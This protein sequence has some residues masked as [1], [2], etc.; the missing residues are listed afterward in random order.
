MASISSVSGGNKT[1]SLYNSSNTISGLASGLD[2]ESMIENLVKS[3]QNKITTLNQKATKIQWKQESYR[4]I[5]SQM[6]SFSNKYTSYTSSTNLLSSSF[7]TNAIKVTAQG[8][9]ADKVTASGKTSSEIQL[10]S[11][12]DLASA[13]RY[14][15]ASTL[16]TGDG[17]SLVASEALNLSGTTTLGTLK[18]SLSLTYGDKVISISFDEVADQIVA[19]EPQDGTAEEKAQAKAEA[20]AKAIQ[21]KLGDQS[22]SFTSGET[23]KASDRIE[24]KAENGTI[25]FS[26]KGSGGNSV[27]LSAASSTIKDALGLNLDNAK[28]NK[29]A[30]ITLTDATKL[31][32]NIST[33]KYLSGKSMNISLN[34]QTKTIKLP[35]T[36]DAGGNALDM[37]AEEYTTA[38]QTAIDKAFGSEKVKVGS[39]GGKLSFTVAEGSDLLI[40][41]DVGEVLG[42]GKTAST[43][44][45]TSK[46]LGDLMP[47]FGEGEQAFVING[48]TV[49]N[50]SKD[51]KLSDVMSAINANTE[52]GVK[53][54]YSKTSKEFTFT[55]ADTGSQGKIELGEGLAQAMFGVVPTEEGNG[56]TKGKDATFSV[57]VNG[58]TPISMTRSSNSVEIDG[59][60]LNFKDKFTAESGKV[61]FKSSADSD[62]IVTAIKSMIDDY[63]AMV[64]EI[65]SSYS[66]LPS[67]KTNGSYY[68]PLTDDDASSMSESAIRQYEEKAKQGL[69]FGDSVLSGLY[70]KLSGIFTTSG[71]D[72]AMLRKMGI[73]TAYSSGDGVINLTL[74]ESKLREMLESDPD[75]VAEAFTKSTESGASTNGIMQKM[76]VQMDN[77]ARLSGATKGILV[78]RAGTPLSSLSLLSNTYQKEIDTLN[79]DIESWQDKLAAKVDSY[80]SQFTRLETLINQMNSQSST[81][82]GM[83][84]G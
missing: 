13:A 79:K 44:L 38:L 24:V 48:V 77:Y 12:T 2:T 70:E 61:T 52:A 84:G 28:E 75:A 16:S 55:A 64:T 56:Y 7:F 51:S 6:S 14:T 83:L 1:S 76:K 10:N 8:A 80:T 71:N 20:L 40:N 72:G 31:T 49:G 22:I 11:V 74:D 58:G 65:K 33:A 39:E 63:N 5:I 73:T 43:Y 9:N 41:T 27:Y 78:E 37:S 3:Y 21:A 69:L 25:T 47:D 68:E 45:D 30:T 53:V 19:A 17:K 59:L 23:V 26:D 32:D 66:T 36:I 4:G 60:T 67:Q 35:E 62:K 82:S 18:G 29:P 81:L 54:S 50:F 15:A 46:T 34:G 57:T 42:I